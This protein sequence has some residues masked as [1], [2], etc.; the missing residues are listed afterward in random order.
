M[1]SILITGPKDS[2]KELL[3]ESIGYRFYLRVVL[4]IEDSVKRIYVVITSLCQMD[5]VAPWMPLWV[6]AYV[7]HPLWPCDAWLLGFL[8]LHLVGP[9]RQVE[10]LHHAR[11]PPIKTVK[12][13]I[14]LPSP[15]LKPVWHFSSCSASQWPGPPNQPSRRRARHM[16]D[17]HQE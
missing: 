7:R 3:S 9:I 5:F 11:Y 16:L 2:K 15:W 12:H 8:A 14:G 4:P 17:H 6:L 10:D 1:I 13:V